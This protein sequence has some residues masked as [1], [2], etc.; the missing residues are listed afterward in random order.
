MGA[1]C[2]LLRELLRF[3]RVRRALE[4]AVPASPRAVARVSDLARRQGVAMPR[5]RSLTAVH[6][7]FVFGLLDPVLYLDPVSE[8]GVDATVLTHELAH[9]RRRDHWWIA[10][11]LTGLCL[12]WWNP[13]YWIARGRMRAAAELACDAA[14]VERF[15]HERLAYARALVDAAERG[16]GSGEGTSMTVLGQRRRGRAPPARVDPLGLADLAGVVAVRRDP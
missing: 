16:A 12:H 13:I 5:V 10:L 6:S 8:E 1:A 14:V 4:G 11:E 9:L 15:P 2:F 7:P 3:A